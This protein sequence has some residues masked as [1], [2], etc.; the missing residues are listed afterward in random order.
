[1][2]QIFR[3]LYHVYGDHVDELFNV[4]THDFSLGPVNVRQYTDP[5]SGC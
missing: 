5:G 1:M 3:G 4:C 2:T